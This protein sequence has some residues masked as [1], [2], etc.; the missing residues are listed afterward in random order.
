[1]LSEPSLTLALSLTECQLATSSSDIPLVVAIINFLSTVA[2]SAKL[3]TSH[4]SREEQT[5][6]EEQVLLYI[7]REYL[8]YISAFQ[9]LRILALFQE[10][11]VLRHVMKVPP[12]LRSES[13][14]E[15]AYSKLVKALV[16]VRGQSR[17]S[18]PLRV[19]KRGSKF[20][21]STIGG[22]NKAVKKVREPPDQLFPETCD[23]TLTMHML[24]I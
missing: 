24:L 12:H 21:R 3:S 10:K 6:T 18:P 13:S 4:A 20:R 15:Q 2:T 14:F 16:P 7:D 8:I 9:A 1:M 22:S 11:F 19:P 17:T 23:P 5:Y